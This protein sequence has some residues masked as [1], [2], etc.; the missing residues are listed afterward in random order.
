M[1]NKQSREK[2]WYDMF[3][4]LVKDFC[5]FWWFDFHQGVL[6]FFQTLYISRW[7]PPPSLSCS[8]ITFYRQHFLMLLKYWSMHGGH[9]TLNKMKLHK[10]HK[11]SSHKWVGDVWKSS[12]KHK[13]S[14]L[15]ETI[16]KGMAPLI[17]SKSKSCKHM[18]IFEL[19]PLTLLL[20]MVSSI[21]CDTIEQRFH[22]TLATKCLAAE[23]KY[24]VGD[25]FHLRTQ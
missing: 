15:L 21:S 12:A 19:F 14:D 23:L 10:T 1:Q 18:F 13:H 3:A 16:L 5:L 7:N 25:T 17:A 6:F 20:W 9:R 2:R 22:F 8:C 4:L 24:D 11:V